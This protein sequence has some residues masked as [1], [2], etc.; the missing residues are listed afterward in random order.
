MVGGAEGEL[1]EEARDQLRKVLDSYDSEMRGQN[2]SDAA[3]AD[4]E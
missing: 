2:G 4:D 1:T 3:R